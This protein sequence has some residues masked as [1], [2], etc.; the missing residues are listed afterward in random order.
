MIIPLLT[1][2]LNPF[3]PLLLHTS[4]KHLRPELPVLKELVIEAVGDLYREF[5]GGGG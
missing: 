2:H 5:L 1:L 3:Q 4:L